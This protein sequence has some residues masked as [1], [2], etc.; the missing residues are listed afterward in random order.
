MRRH[1][2]TAYHRKILKGMDDVHGQLMRYKKRIN[3]ELVI[4]RD[5]KTVYIKPS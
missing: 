2:L 1:A 5:N 4:M 3:S